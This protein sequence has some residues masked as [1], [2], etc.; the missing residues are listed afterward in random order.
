MFV[1]LDSDRMIATITVD[2]LRVN[3][4]EAST[5]V[6]GVMNETA[7]K[8]N[9]NEVKELSITSVEHETVL[10]QSSKLEA[11]DARNLERIAFV[12]L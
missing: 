1:T 8:P 2:T 6:E 11:N 5:T 10:L 4:H 7:L 12:N 9:G 3:V